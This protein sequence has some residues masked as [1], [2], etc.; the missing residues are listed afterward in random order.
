MLITTPSACCTTA[1]A[2]LKIRI[3]LVSAGPDCSIVP[4]CHNVSNCTDNGICVDFDVCKCNVGWTGGNCTQ[5]S[6][7]QLDYCSGKL[8]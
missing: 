8:L 3:F 1:V 2:I 6:C 4:T 5:Y 7:E